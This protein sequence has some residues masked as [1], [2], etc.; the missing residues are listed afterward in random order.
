M[1]EKTN[2]AESGIIYLIQAESGLCKI[3]AT[4][5]LS[6]IFVPYGATLAWKMP[7]ANMVVTRACLHRRFADRHHHGDWFTLTPEEIAWIEALDDLDTPV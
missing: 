3:G 1:S 5:D 6:T 2:A 4:R 7:T